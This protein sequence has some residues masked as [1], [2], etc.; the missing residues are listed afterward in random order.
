MEKRGKA[1]TSGQNRARKKRYVIVI[2][3]VISLAIL[4]AGIGIVGFA[5]NESQDLTRIDSKTNVEIELKRG[6]VNIDGKIDIE[7]VYFLIE[8]VLKGGV[9]PDPIEL[10]DVNGDK[11]VNNADITYLISYISPRGP[12]PVPLQTGDI[13]KDGVIDSD[14]LD[15]LT[16]YILRAGPAPD[17]IELGDVNGNNDVSVGDITY[18]ENYLS[19]NVDAPDPVSYLIGDLD[20]N[21]IINNADL[22]LL[23]DYIL[24]AGTPPS[25]EWIGDVNGNGDVSNADILYL[26]NYLNGATGASAPVSYVVGDLDKNNK[27][28]FSDLN[29]LISYVLQGGVAPSPLWIGDVNGDSQVKTSDIT[30]L[31]NYLNKN[32]PAPVLKERGDL[33]KDGSIN[34]LDVNYLVNYVFKGGAAPSPLWIGDVNGDWEV[35][36]SDIVYLISY[37]SP[38]GPAPVPLDIKDE[39]TCADGD[40][41][42]N[43][44]EWAFTLVN[45]QDIY[46]DSCRDSLTGPDLEKGSYLKELYCESGELKEEII[47]CDDGCEKGACI[48][49]EE[50]GGISCEPVVEGGPRIS[51]KTRAEIGGVLKYCSPFTLKYESAKNEGQ[52]CV[53]DYQCKSNVCI[54]GKCTLLKQELEK[55]AGLL[56]KIWCAI[57]H[58]VDVFSRD[59][60]GQTASNN[61]YLGCIASDD[62]GNTGGNEVDNSA[63]RSTN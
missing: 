11:I 2:S 26:Q 53:E 34:Q 3:I 57:I 49:P 46:Q 35:K 42:K 4:I 12:K 17:P 13:N 8:Y 18:L 14:D 36:S 23:T 50:E 19:R 40:F 63:S 59:D 56:Q 25:P 54:E 31:E 22:D 62:Q 27:I 45:G 24:R 51:P 44:Y 29:L 6:D 48:V 16:D 37:I 43:Y 33:T 28:D 21:K 1:S 58:P 47:R 32:A 38:T 61:G 15:L 30:Y 41:G 10:G 55:Q 39:I 9:A 20:K 52:S 60:A 5:I 7:D